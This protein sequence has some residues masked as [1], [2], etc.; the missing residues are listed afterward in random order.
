MNCTDLAPK[1]SEAALKYLGLL[2]DIGSSKK[3][4]TKEE[5]KQPEP[6]DKPE[7]QDDTRDTD[8]NKSDPI[9]D[10]SNSSRMASNKPTPEGGGSV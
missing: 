5:V 10:I 3:E 4:E 9:P 7:A 8:A 2:N 1:D 6:T